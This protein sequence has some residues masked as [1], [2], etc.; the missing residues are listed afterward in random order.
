MVSLLLALSLIPRTLA[1]PAPG[2]A[3]VLPLGTPQIAQHRAKPAL[4][5]GGIQAVA[6]G[7]A[8][9]SMVAMRRA[10]E[11]GDVDRELN[12]RL[13]SMGTV[14]VGAGAW[15]ASVTEASQHQQEAA[16]RAAAARAWSA[17]ARPAPEFPPTRDQ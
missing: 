3:L 16:A 14:T 12:L 4:L 15:F 9:A 5:F 6:F 10:S 1:E 8:A 7:G 17:S 13:V 2:W 11:S